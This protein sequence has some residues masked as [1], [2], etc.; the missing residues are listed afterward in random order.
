M[1]TQT[2]GL[3]QYAL[4]LALSETIPV[5]PYG[6]MLHPDS[7]VDPKDRGKVPGMYYEGGWSSTAGWPEFQMDAYSATDLDQLGANVGLKMGPTYCALDVDVLD[8]VT[9]RAIRSK[10]AEIGI[11]APIRVGKA[12]KFL[13]LFRVEGE[14]VRRRQYPVSLGETTAMV[15]VM[16]LTRKGRPT[17][18]VIFGTHPS[19]APYQWDTDPAHDTLPTITQVDMDQLVE[20]V[21]AV[22]D[23]YGWTRGRP[24][25]GGGGTGRTSDLGDPADE[26]LARDVLA[27]VPNDN[28]AWEDWVRIGLC[29]RTVFGY[30]EGWPLWLGW[31]QQAGKYEYRETELRWSSFEPDGSLSMGT[32]VH[33]ARQHGALPQFLSDRV[34]RDADLRRMRQSGMP[35]EAPAVPSGVTGAP[36]APPQPTQA[37]MTVTAQDGAFPVLDPAD[38]DYSRKSDGTIT[39]NSNNAYLLLKNAP[40]FSEPFGYN[41][42]T[43]EAVVKMPYPGDLAGQKYPRPLQDID[44]VRMYH[45]VQ[46]MPGWGNIS[47]TAVMDALDRLCFLNTEE[48]VQNYLNWLPETPPMGLLDTWL[49]TYLGVER[50]NDAMTDEYVRQ[51]GR[52][53]LIGAV[54]RAME[55]GCQMDNALILEGAQG[56]GKSSALRALCPDPNWFGDGLPDFH[57][58][59]AAQ[60]LQGIWIVEMAELTNLRKS[61]VEEV[62]RFMTQRVDKFRPAYGRKDVVLPRRMVFAGSTNRDQ[63][64]KDTDGE[65]RFWPV[66]VGR[67]D[68]KGLAEVRDALWREA[69]DA[70]KSGND[71]HLDPIVASFAT[72]QQQERVEDSPY[73]DIVIEAVQNQNVVTVPFIM[74]V[75]GDKLPKLNSA[76]RND[77]HAALRQIGFTY[78][79]KQ[80]KENGKRPRLWVRTVIAV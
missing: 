5:I 13:M 42:F 43:D 37:Q 58:K 47:K 11:T 1:T 66:R 28:R 6:A 15:E 24:T 68:V 10:L 63:Y 59:D 21:L 48:P 39:A 64:L 50:A 36:D 19:G 31:S 49:F 17:Q 77:L 53:W 2:V 33:E 32:L 23:T 67:I 40:R 65:R 51:V 54:A 72:Q 45:A 18:A 61:E 16:G 78:T 41:A 4:S 14:A 70:W 55:P 38:G 20:T 73:L 34:T 9:V 69:F 22:C 80:R 8:E 44:Y 3:H 76:V 27:Y 46:Q 12:P 29:I 75:V 62:R 7:R 25:S 30:D 26:G 71:W 79:K 57:T 60:Y 52:C 56:L 35:I 74:S